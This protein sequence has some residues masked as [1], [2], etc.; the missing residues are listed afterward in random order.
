MVAN[1]IRMAADLAAS[2]YAARMGGDMARLSDALEA[3]RHPARAAEPAG[4]AP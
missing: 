1:A 4:A 3:L 2:N